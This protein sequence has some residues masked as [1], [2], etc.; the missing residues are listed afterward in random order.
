MEKYESKQVQILRPAA[1]IYRALSDFS[2]FTPILQN[3]VDKWEATADTCSFMAK[4]FP[5]K[6]RIADRE[7]NKLVKIT[8]DG[9]TPFPFNAWIQLKEVEESSNPD[10]RMRL[11]LHIELNMMMKMM[12]GKKIK[13]VLDQVADQIATGFNNAPY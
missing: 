6:L 5:V 1:I 8:A 3:K 4:G 10:T 9:N 11:V 7:E 13:E 12:I 2:N